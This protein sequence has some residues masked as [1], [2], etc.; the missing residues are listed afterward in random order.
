M[1]SVPAELSPANLKMIDEV[2]AEAMNDVLLSQ[3]YG[4]ATPNP[5]S[6]ESAW[7]R[8]QHGWTGQD[9]E[10]ILPRLG[11]QVGSPNWRQFIRGQQARQIVTEMLNAGDKLLESPESPR[12]A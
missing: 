12:P 6:T 2:H 1:N 9:W 11:G 7:A 4:R 8:W 10:T 5:Y 3:A